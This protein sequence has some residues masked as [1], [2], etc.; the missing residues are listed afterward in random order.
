MSLDIYLDS[1]TGC[2]SGSAS[3]KDIPVRIDGQTK[4]ISREEWDSM[5]MG[6]EPV[7]YEGEGNS[8]VFSANITHNLTRMAK[9]AGIYDLLWDLTIEGEDILTAG[10]MTE[11]LRMGIERMESDPD[12]YKTYNP[13]NGWGSYD[14]FIPWLKELLEACEEFPDAHVT[15]WK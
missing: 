11:Q 13:T 5:G 1:P 4:M 10:Q 2:K 7:T 9:A 8:R 15:I 14:D 3:E 12:T 6:F